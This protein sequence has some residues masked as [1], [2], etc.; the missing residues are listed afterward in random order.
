MGGAKAWLLKTKPGSRKSFSK[1]KTHFTLRVQSVDMHVNFNAHDLI[2][3]VELLPSLQQY[4]GLE[5]EQS[6][7]A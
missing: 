3:R 5:R 1:W 2:T 7:N 6:L 4:D